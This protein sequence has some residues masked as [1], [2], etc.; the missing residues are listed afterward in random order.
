MDHY[1]HL[2]GFHLEQLEELAQPVQLA[3]LGDLALDGRAGRHGS[4]RSFFP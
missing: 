2:E 1:V 3:E 4:P